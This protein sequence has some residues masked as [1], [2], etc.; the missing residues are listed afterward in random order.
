LE[1]GGGVSKKQP[2]STAKPGLPARATQGKRT[3]TPINEEIAK[4]GEKKRGWGREEKKQFVRNGVRGEKIWAD[5]DW[6][7]NALEAT[8]WKQLRGGGEKAGKRGRK[9][10][11]GRWRTETVQRLREETKPAEWKTVRT[12]RPRKRSGFKKTRAKGQR[13]ITAENGQ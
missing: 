1:E 4:R 2:V 7:S 6:N 3:H 5:K 12:A 9:F 11:D 10:K 13:A 8:T